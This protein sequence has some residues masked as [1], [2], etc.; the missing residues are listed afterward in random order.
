MRK[1]LTF[2][3]IFQLILILTFFL[4]FFKSCQLDGPSAEELEA[5]RIAD[6][7]KLADSLACVKAASIKMDKADNFYHKD[8]IV[9]KDKATSHSTN[10][11]DSGFVDL[12]KDINDSIK[13]NKKILGYFNRINDDTIIIS[14]LD[15][16][17][18]LSITNGLISKFKFLR[19]ILQ[20]NKGNSGIGFIIDYWFAFIYIFGIYV[21]LLLGLFVMIFKFLDYKRYSVPIIILNVTG[22]IFI[23]NSYGSSISFGQYLWGYWICLFIWLI[24]ILIDI[25]SIYLIKKKK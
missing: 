23:I 14:R 13:S 12:A 8:S 21:S 1:L 25:L 18:G 10:Y 24:Q 4:S 20:P 7:T 3:K 6:S 19:P 11:K 9:N 22:F 5:Q 16:K 2:S 15:Y 17:K